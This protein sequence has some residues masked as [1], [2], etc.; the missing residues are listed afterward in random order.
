MGAKLIVLHH[1]NCAIFV[2]KISPPNYGGEIKKPLS[3][4]GCGTW[5]IYSMRM[6]VWLGTFSYK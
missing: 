4:R 3:V 1:S 2:N 5:G 6:S